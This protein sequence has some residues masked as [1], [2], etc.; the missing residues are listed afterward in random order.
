MHSG[1]AQRPGTNG[2]LIPRRGDNICQMGGRPIP[3]TRRGRR[4]RPCTL[5][6]YDRLF[7]RRKDELGSGAVDLGIDVSGPAIFS[8]GHAWHPSSST[9]SSRIPPGGSWKVAASTPL[10][11]WDGVILDLRQRSFAPMSSR[12]Q[13]GACVRVKYSA[14]KEKTS[15]RQRQGTTSTQQSELNNQRDGELLKSMVRYEKK[16]V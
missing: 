16:N 5:L 6:L 15:K 11:A 13:Q 2:R 4:R 7:L 1:R 14:F 3:R 10:C 12:P 8:H 9:L